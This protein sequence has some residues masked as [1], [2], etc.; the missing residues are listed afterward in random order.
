M[1]AN[2][3]KLARIGQWVKNSVVM[4]AL[5]FAGEIQ[6]THRIGLALAATALFCLLSSA[7]Y[8]FND[9]VDR[10][11]DRQ[12]P[13]KKD[14]PIASGAVSP[15]TAAIL[16]LLLLVVGLLG[17]WFINTNFVFVSIAFVVVNLLYSLLLKNVVIV[18]V[19]TLAI[20]FV[21]RAYAGA[22]A[23]DV[24]ASK[25][26]LINTL[27]LALFLGFGKRRHE[28]VLLEEGAATHRT[29]LSRYSPYLLD[30]LMG[31]T[32][33]SV[34]VMYMLYTFSTEVSQKLGTENLFVTI[35]FV[36]YGI[37]RYLYLIHKE[38]KGG[39]PTKLMFTDK[40]ILLTV[41]LWLLTVIVVLYHLWG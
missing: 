39:S 28:L 36:V 10:D 5:V 1:F 23:I 34:V 37:F 21:V 29:S 41:C 12:H 6:D 11:K 3:I 17:A 15:S 19:M 38:E 7:V 18:D 9:L 13:S 35:P 14:R 32:T 20:S 31:V 27:L 40:P 33:A 24:P 25:W 2:L 30:Q 16:A 22:V 8:T 26:M 4:A